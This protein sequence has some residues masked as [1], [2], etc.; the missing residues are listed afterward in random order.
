MRY[1]YPEIVRYLEAGSTVTFVAFVA[2]RGRMTIRANVSWQTQRD[3]DNFPRGFQSER[4]ALTYYP[5]CLNVLDVDRNQWI[6]LKWDDII[7]IKI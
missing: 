5:R 4:E 7:E 6:T 1:T 2:G 3:L